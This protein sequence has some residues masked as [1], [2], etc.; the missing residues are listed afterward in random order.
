[1]PTTAPGVSD[2][3]VR[4]RSELEPLFLRTRYRAFVAGSE[5]VLRCGE[6]HPWLDDVLRQ[7]GLSTWAFLT[8]W[9]PGG[10]LLPAGENRLRQT[11]LQERIQDAG[12]AFYPGVGELDDWSEESLLILG[13]SLTQVHDWA[14]TFG[15]AAFVWGELDQPARLEW[16]LPA[17]EV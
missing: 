1:M 10:D 3:I 12:L 15:Q 6:R 13:P 16:L 5:L 8:A 14:S 17:K 11:Q 4:T 7:H 9:N 2:S